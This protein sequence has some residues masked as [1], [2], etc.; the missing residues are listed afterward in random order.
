MATSFSDLIKFGL[1]RSNMSAAISESSQWFRDTSM[2]FLKEIKRIVGSR[3]RIEI[4]RMYLFSYDPKT[5]DKLPYYDKFPLV[6]PIESYSD[7]FLGINFHYLP[8][9]LRARLL[10]A[11]Y[12]TIN[13]KNF[14]ETTKLKISY[15]VL[16]GVTKFKYFQPCVKRYLFSHIRSGFKEIEPNDWNKAILLPTQSFQKANESKVYADSIRKV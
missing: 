1:T 11:L 9:M 8:P 15:N 6:F 2:T 7:G 13:N 3:N 14:D 16:K 5:K 12:D 10:D 4:G